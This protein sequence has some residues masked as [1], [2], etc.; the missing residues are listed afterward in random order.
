MKSN[1]FIML[2]VAF[3]LT[4]AGCSET[5]S[6]SRDVNPIPMPGPVVVQP[7]GENLTVND[8]L[9]IIQTA[10]GAGTF[11][12]L[13]AAVDAADLTDTLKG[14]GPFTVFAPT[15]EAFAKLP[16]GTVEALLNDIPKLK[17]ILLYHVAAGKILASEVLSSGSVK[18]LSEGT[19]SVS[20]SS[21]GAFINQSKIIATDIVTKNGVIHVIDTVLIPSET[22]PS[23]PAL[24]DIVD[25]AVGAGSFKTLA[26]ALGAAGLVE[27]LKSEGPFTVFAPTDEAFAKLPEGTVEALLADIPTLTKIL[28]YHV[29]PGKFEAKDVLSRD[30]WTSANDLSLS[31]STS[32][33]GAFINSSKIIAT[34]VQATNGVIHVI[35]S[36]LIPSK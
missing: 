30:V 19:A 22:E 1:Y 5:K 11:N 18:F 4:H 35:D 14:D 28:L 10:K 8:A 33:A 2:S 36:V 3:S 7:S 12:T 17:S 25:T 20:S 6:S 32:D 24:K 21:E 31:I 13:L 9:D 29:V 26:A 16:A 34:D 23:V 15:D 27:T